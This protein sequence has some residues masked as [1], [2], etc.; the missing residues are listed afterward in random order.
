MKPQQTFPVV[1]INLSGCTVPKL[2]VLSCVRGVQSCV[3]SSN[4]KQNSFFTKHTMECIRDAFVNSHGFMFRAEFDPW[5]MICSGGQSGFVSRY[6]SLFDAYLAQKRDES[7]YRLRVANKRG[8]RAQSVGHC[9]STTVTCSESGD[10]SVV[11]AGTVVQ[12]DSGTSSG[13]PSKVKKYNSLALCTGGRGAQKKL[14]T[15]R[16]RKVR[17]SLPSLWS[18]LW[19]SLSKNY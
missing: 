5:E 2:V 18:D 17:K 14:S 10:F 1:D 3:L 11:G 8:G 13:R 12:G 16:R 7:Y 4:Y 15:P 9:N 6:T 19:A